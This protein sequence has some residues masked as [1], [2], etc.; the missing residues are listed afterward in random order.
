MTT[1]A[2]DTHLKPLVFPHSNDAP[3]LTR[4]HNSLAPVIESPHER[5]RS[6]R[7]DDPCKMTVGDQLIILEQFHA[8]AIQRISAPSIAPTV[9]PLNQR[10]ISRAASI[11]HLHRYGPIVH[12]MF[13]QH[14]APIPESLHAKSRSDIHNHKLI[15]SIHSNEQSGKVSF[16]AVV[17]RLN[18]Q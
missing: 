8:L 1:R 18:K 13:D 3:A 16:Y 6:E 10:A 17:A 11:D 4:P 9:I 14:L 7:T 2:Q 5:H 15:T 12:I